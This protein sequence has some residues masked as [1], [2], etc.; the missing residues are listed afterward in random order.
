MTWRLALL[1]TLLVVLSGCEPP[2]TDDQS[3]SADGQTPLFDVAFDT[4]AT[5]TD[6]SV[7]ATVPSDTNSASD[8]GA[9]ADSDA[10]D[11]DSS[12]DDDSSRLRRHGV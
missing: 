8:G 3:P 2:Q 1:S 5:P 9:K 10:V 4:G 11:A 6:A 7:D 12:S